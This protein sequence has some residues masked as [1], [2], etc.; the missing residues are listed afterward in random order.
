MQQKDRKIKELKKKRVNPPEVQD[1]MN[2]N[3]YLKL[4]I[5]TLEEQIAKLE[6]DEDMIKIEL[7]ESMRMTKNSFD[8]LPLEMQYLPTEIITSLNEILQQVK[9][10]S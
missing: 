4:N 6:K 8:D 9:K 7:R 1:L 5:L 2:E 3:E 10:D